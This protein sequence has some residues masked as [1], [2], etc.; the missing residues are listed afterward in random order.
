MLWTALHWA[1]AAH[2][3]L[4]TPITRLL[5][6]PRALVI[7]GAAL[8]VLFTAELAMFNSEFFVKQLCRT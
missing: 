5:F 2:N 6:K 1:L 4:A 7:L 8:D 3:L